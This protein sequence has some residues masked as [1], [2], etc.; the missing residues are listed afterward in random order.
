M[1]TNI[2]V[3]FTKLCCGT[4][5]D[6]RSRLP[7]LSFFWMV[8][9]KSIFVRNTKAKN[10]AILTIYLFVV[11]SQICEPKWSQWGLNM[12]PLQGIMYTDTKILSMNDSYIVLVVRK[13][14]QTNHR[15]LRWPWQLNAGVITSGVQRMSVTTCQYGAPG[16]SVVSMKEICTDVEGNL[17]KTCSENWL[18]NSNRE[19]ETL[20]YLYLSRN[21]KVWVRVLV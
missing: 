7:F 11:N 16:Y 17:P 2:A 9:L 15:L 3:E 20:I 18:K 21:M 13:R 6:N 10:G 12:E 8:R 4:E 19:L 14:M 5:P 1:K